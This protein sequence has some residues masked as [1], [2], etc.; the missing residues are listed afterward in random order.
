MP[1]LV[2]GDRGARRYQVSQRIDRRQ[3][4]A[5][6]KHFFGN[7]AIARDAASRSRVSEVF[8]AH[9]PFW[10][11]WGRAIGWAFGQKKVGSGDS[12][13]YEAR[14]LRIAEDM[15]WTGAA[16]DVGEFGVR[17]IQLTDQPIEPFDGEALHRSG[18]VFEPVGSMSDA[19]NAAQANFQLRVRVRARLDRLGQLFVRFVKT[20]FGVVY[21][22]LWVIRY[23]YRGRTFQV[24]VDAFNGKVLYGRAPGNTFYRAAMLVGG[25][26]LGAFV[27]VDIPTLMV[28]GSNSSDDPTGLYFFAFLI[29]LAIMAFAY[30]AFRF[31]E[32]YELRGG[33]SPVKVDADMVKSLTTEAE[34]G[35]LFSLVMNAVESSIKDAK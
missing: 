23:L 22:P 3:A 17:S 24:V 33:S 31:G 35:G 29:G 19:R 20:R 1:S 11:L 9:L 15:V 10:S 6:L 30:R 4:V 16:C 12:S 2:R 27:M 5:M 8:L 32:Q 14:E 28:T 7:W 34:S 25:M 18:L 13:H 26:A 21:Y